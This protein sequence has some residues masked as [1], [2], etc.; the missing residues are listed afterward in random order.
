[1]L[2]A[3]L[4]ALLLGPAVPLVSGLHVALL[5]VRL[6][7]TRHD[8]AH[9]EVIHRA[10]LAFCRLLGCA[11]ITIGLIT[12]LVG[13]DGHG[14]VGVRTFTHLDVVS[15]GLFSIGLGLV[16]PVGHDRSNL[17][18]IHGA[19]QLVA[20]IDAGRQ[21]LGKPKNSVPVHGVTSR[22]NSSM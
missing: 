17:V 12:N 18:L 3:C 8:V 14:V 6:G 21:A 2:H 10:D 1:M 11:L 20:E 19:A 9:V 22:L 16:E 15:D 7:D 4:R 5:D 13:R